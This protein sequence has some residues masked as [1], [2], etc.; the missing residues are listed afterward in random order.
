VAG[1]ALCAR[2]SIDRIVELPVEQPS[3]CAFGGEDL[4]TLYVTS[5]REGP[6]PA[7]SRLSPGP[8]SLLALDPGVKGWAPPPFGG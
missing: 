2:R 3:K 6:V 4:S 8:G 1:G 7:R 5:A